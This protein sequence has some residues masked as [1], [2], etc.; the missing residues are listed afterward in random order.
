MTGD[1]QGGLR[2]AMERGADVSVAGREVH[3]F[4]AKRDVPDLAPF[5]IVEDGEKSLWIS[6]RTGQICRLK[7]GEATV[8]GEADEAVN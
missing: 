2:L 6:Y 5:N 1:G 4:L 3:A 7:N 8:F